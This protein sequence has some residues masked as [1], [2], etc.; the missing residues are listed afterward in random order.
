MAHTF[1]QVSLAHVFLWSDNPRHESIE[2]QSAIIAELCAKEKVLPLMKHI[3][4][5]GLNPLEQIGLISSPNSKSKSYYPAEGNRRL[6]ALMLLNDPDRAPTKFLTQARTI[7]TGWVQLKK[8]NAVVFD[9][10]DSAK[11][12]MDLLHN[13]DIPGVARLKWDAAQKAR[14]AGSKSRNDRAFR[15]LEYAES[16]GLFDKRDREKRLTTVQRY[17]SARGFP[18][19]IGLSF[20][21][22]GT[23]KRQLLAADFDRILGAFLHDLIPVPPATLAPVN[24]RA[25]ST[26]MQAYGTDLIRREGLDLK[27][28]SPRRLE[29]ADETSEADSLTDSPPEADVPYTIDPEKAPPPASP[30]PSKPP[31]PPMQVEA[32]SEIAAAL[33]ELKNYKLRSL[34]HS[35][36]TL[37]L[38]DHAIL[39]S[40]GIWSFFESLTAVDGRNE[41]TS[42]ASFLSKRKLGELVPS[43]RD[44]DFTAALSNAA[45]WGN[46]AKHSP[47]VAPVNG[48]QIALDMKVLEP[49]VLALI[50]RCVG[51]A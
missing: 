17:L 51:G 8:L 13:E 27:H 6:C 3:A 33:D 30:P 36:C 49:V 9:K 28:I 41:G 43:G 20:E 26:E 31:V 19:M 32:N 1:S 2:A 12:W 47:L 5:N 37:R 24:S 39:V 18:A 44:K 10:L 23:P 38:H 45:T 16:K 48:A 40:V 29:E 46:L 34:Y 50:R 25:K 42:F 21:K 35:I 14:N 11:V 15:L 7:A 4:K 22:D